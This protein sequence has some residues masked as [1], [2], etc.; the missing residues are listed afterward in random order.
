MRWKALFRQARWPDD[1]RRGK[2]GFKVL[3]GKI[4]APLV[5]FTEAFEKAEAAAQDSEHVRNDDCTPCEIAGATERHS[6]ANAVVEEGSVC[7]FDEA[8]V[9][10]EAAETA[11]DHAGLKEV[12]RI[13]GVGQDE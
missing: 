1:V 2:A 7:G 3:R 12:G 5:G 13:P 10:L 6:K 9:V 4:V 11:R 8:M